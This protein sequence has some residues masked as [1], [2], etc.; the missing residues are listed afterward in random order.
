MNLIDTYLSSFSSWTISGMSALS[1]VVSTVGVGSN[2]G[3]GSNWSNGSAG[4]PSLLFK[5]IIENRLGG[6]EYSRLIYG[7]HRLQSTQV[8]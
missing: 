2:F 1:G 4:S 6:T 5:H 8:A 7:I 3:N